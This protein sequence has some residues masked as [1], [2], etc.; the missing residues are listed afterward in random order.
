M[1]KVKRPIKISNPQKQT[2]TMNFRADDPG[3]VQYGNFINYYQFH[4]AQDRIALLPNDVWLPKTHD[5]HSN[6]SPYLLLDVGCNAGDVTQL[7]L[8]YLTNHL[9]KKVEILAIDI[10]P[11][12]IKRA[13]ENNNAPQNINF[14]CVDIMQ[15]D[16]S[17][18][19]N[20]LKARNATKFDAVCCFSITMWIHLNHGDSGLQDFLK[21]CSHFAQLLIVEP[22]PW[23]CYRTAVRRMRRSAQ[24]TF[25][26]FGQLKWTINIEEDIRQYLEN[27]LNLQMIHE[28]LPTKW[29]RRIWFY[30]HKEAGNSNLV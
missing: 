30:R 21:K 8:N 23:K 1:F 17:E 25:P 22:Q 29:M 16:L 12:L 3:A 24:E 2:N 27:H 13:K 7:L 4:S 10:D 11:T 26:N 28:T 20:F 19:K 5:T 9:N 18:I 14:A 6:E 15:T